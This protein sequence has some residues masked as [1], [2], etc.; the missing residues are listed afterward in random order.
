MT[1]N[2][3]A[4]TAEEFA[5]WSEADD[6]QAIKQTVEQ[7]KPKHVIKNGEYWALVNGETFKLP[8]DLNV[9]DFQTLM[10]VDDT[11]TIDALENIVNAFAGETEAKRINKL[12]V[13]SVGLLLNDYAAVLSKVQGAELGK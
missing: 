10:Q 3:A 2:N 13:V 8:L 5:N 4:P 9:N 11:G 6:E 1:S 7:Y 12:P